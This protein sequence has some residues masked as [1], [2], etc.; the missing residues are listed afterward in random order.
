[1]V[2]SPI[3]LIGFHGDEFE[4]IQRNIIQKVT[5]IKEIKVKIYECS[6]NSL[7]LNEKRTRDGLKMNIHASFL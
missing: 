5:K 1:M 2:K 7:L 4:K 3:W 6:S